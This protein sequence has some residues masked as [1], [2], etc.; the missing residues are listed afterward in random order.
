MQRLIQNLTM[1]LPVVIVFCG[2][3][4]SASA[5]S[6]TWLGTLGG[7]QSYAFG[8]SDNGVVVGRARDAQGRDRAFRW[9]AQTGMQDLGTLGGAS[10]AKGVSADGSVVVGWSETASG[11]ERAFRWTESTGMVDLL[12]RRSRANGVSADGSVVVGSAGFAGNIHAFRWTQATGIQDLGTLG[13]HSSDGYGISGNGRVVVGGAHNTD[14]WQRAFRWTAETG[15]QNLGNLGGAWSAGFGAS[16]DGSVVVGTATNTENYRAFRWTES[17]GMQD[18]GTLPG[19]N[20]SR[21][22]GVSGDGRVVVGASDDNAFRWTAGTGMQNL[23]SVYAH[24]LGEGSSLWSANAISPNGRYIVGWGYNAAT[25]RYEAF[26]L[27]TGEGRRGG[28]LRWL[29]TLGGEGTGDYSFAFDVSAGGR[30]V[31]GASSNA[32]G[33]QRAFRWTPETGMQDLGLEGSGT[34]R[35]V[36]GNGRVVV[37]EDVD[38]VTYYSRGFRWTPET[39]VQYLATLGGNFNS[40]YGVSDDGSVVAGSATLPGDFVYRA[41]RWTQATG[42]QDL[43][44]LGGYSSYAHDISGDGR[45]V[46]GWASDASLNQ[47]AFRWTAETGMQSLGALHGSYSTAF[48]VSQDGRVVVGVSHNGSGYTVAFRWTADAGMQDLGTLG[49]NFSAA[50]DVSA[51][52]KVVVGHSEIEPGIET[53]RAFLWTES[54]GMQNL[55]DLYAHLL[56]DGSRLWYA[57]AVSPDARYIVGQGW[58][59]SAGRYEAF[60]LDTIGGSRQIAGNL[61]LQDF[62]G[63]ITQIPIAVQLRPAEASP[64]DL[65]IYLSADGSYIIP[66]VEPGVYDIAFKAS[67]WLRVVVRGVDVTDGDV[68]GVDVSLINGDID[69]DNEVTLFDFG[70]LVAAFGSMPGDISWNADADLDGDEE[71]TLFDFGILVRN[72][73]AT[74]DD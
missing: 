40:A 8:V 10:E 27:D 24:L 52:G 58:N 11:Q 4:V 5:Q 30:V 64:V 16:T 69:G 31:V 45:V 44:T 14:G 21:G 46:V 50:F 68:S 41:F 12:G 2:T 54:T 36:S 47:F 43:G 48:G 7:N 17:T 38:D 1:V 71:V 13:G 72:F 65:L 26:L 70:R 35:G 39:G 15:M 3:I 33:Q 74:G 23:N 22:Y 6:L 73:G 66:D 56:T 49:G 20:W 55:N 61:L 34:A 62:A 59:A 60:L 28:S 9:T 42:T 25:G 51:D 29:G 32:V 53:Y 18:L 57:S 67:H 19:F 37:G 63:D